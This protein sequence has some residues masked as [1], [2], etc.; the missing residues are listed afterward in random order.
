M[1]FFNPRKMSFRFFSCLLLIV[2]SDVAWAKIDAAAI[3]KEA[4]AIRNPKEDFQMLV[5]IQS[6]G[7]EEKEFKVMT[8]GNNRT[9]VETLA[10]R[11]DKG[12]DLLM[13]DENMWVFIPNLKRTVRVSLNQKLSGEAANGD[14]SRMRWAMDYAAKIVGSDVKSW[15][16][17][18]EANKK[19]LTYE[20]IIAFVEKGSFRPL[21]AKYLTKSG[22]VLKDAE[23][24]A[25][26]LLAGKVRPS[27]I[28]IKDAIKKGKFS[29]IVIKEM[30][31]KSLPSS[32]F[33]LSGFQTRSR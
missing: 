17:L 28:V 10:P 13:V 16:L 21:G 6:S 32:K 31:V 20:K 1:G 23:F 2:L 7:G 27:Q 25:Y 8:K 3:L 15:T 24:K 18:L 33:N 5:T 19:G 30:S 11:R 14:I 22:K 9:I 29:T 26:K 12:R 4:D